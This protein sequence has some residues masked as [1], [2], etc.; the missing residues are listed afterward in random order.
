MLKYIDDIFES[1]YGSKYNSDGIAW[2]TYYSYEIKEM[3]NDYH[4]YIDIIAFVDILTIDISDVVKFLVYLEGIH[5][6]NNHIIKYKNFEDKPR[7]R[8]TLRFNVNDL[9]SEKEVLQW[10]VDMNAGGIPHTSEEIDRVKAM[11]KQIESEE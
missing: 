10:Y 3:D 4:S 11:I 2:S 1:L 7:M 6:G 8:H 5:I 9:K